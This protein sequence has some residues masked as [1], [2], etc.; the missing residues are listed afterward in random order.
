MK[1]ILG[2]GISGLI[3]ATFFDDFILITKRHTPIFQGAFYLHCGENTEY[4][5]NRLGF[6]LSKKV[7]KA[8]ILYNGKIYT[9]PT[10]ELRKIYWEQK[11]YQEGSPGNVFNQGNLQFEAYNI[12]FSAF[13]D[14]LLETAISNDVEIWLTEVKKIDLNSKKLYLENGSSYS[15]EK[16]ISTIPYPVFCELADISPK[17]IRYR[18][19][20]IGRNP[21]ISVPDEFDYLYILDPQIS[22]YRATKAKNGSYYESLIR[23]ERIIKYGKIFY[24]KAQN[25]PN[26]YYLGRYAEWKPHIKV[27]DVVRRV[28]EWKRQGIMT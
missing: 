26:V 13:Y 6:S 28:L 11:L 20:F 3:A 15:F 5:L 9:E 17:G 7:I 24:G 23:G 19:I 1:Y 10:K 12:D 16:I 18:N 8:G 27:E 21:F 2:G 25:V 14:I 22:Y 4:L